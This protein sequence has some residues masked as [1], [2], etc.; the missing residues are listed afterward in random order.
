VTLKVYDVRGREIE[1]LVNEKQNAGT[2]EVEFDAGNLPSGAYFYRMN[3][4]L[5]SDTKKLMVIK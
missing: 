4:G 3:S 5:F 1:T 2:Y